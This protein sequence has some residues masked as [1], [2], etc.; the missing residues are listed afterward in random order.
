M[1]GTNR[2]EINITGGP[3]I[4]LVE[5][6]LPENIGMVARA[7]ANFGLSVL[8]LVRP[9]EEFP[10]EKAIAAA[11]KAHHV[12]EEAQVF[13]CLKEAVSDLNFLFATTARRRDNF[14]LVL[15]PNEAMA[16]A[17]VKDQK[18]QKVG[19]LFGRERWGLTNEEISLADEIVTYPVNPAFSSLNIAQAV[20]LIAYE[21][22]LSVEKKCAFVDQEHFI[23]AKKESLHSFFGQLEDA[24]D[25]RGYFRPVERK[26]IMAQNLRSV[27]T[28][29]KFSEEEIKLLRGVIS[30]LDHFSPDLPRGV[31]APP[32]RKRKH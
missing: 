7:M 12:L 14:K 11:S 24:L 2:K 32:Q 4:I 5:P 25:C 26:E 13:S 9:R 18:H 20:L 21:W 1:A 23:P 10:H 28:R 22:R 17:Y 30:S 19:V 27:L 15:E 8:R 16:K 6:Q 31:G 3:V 29:A